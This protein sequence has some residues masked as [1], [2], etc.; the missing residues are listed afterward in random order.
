MTMRQN[1]RTY[2]DSSVYLAFLKGE[3][4]QAASGLTRAELARRILSSAE[5]GKLEIFTSAVTI[6]E[7]RRVG[8]S[9]IRFQPNALDAINA[10]FERTSTKMVE[11]SRELALRAQALATGYG[12]RTMDA[13]HLASAEFANC[14]ELFM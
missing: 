3:T 6:V 8:N 5:A 13:I 2:L 12:L 11:V 14:R 1:E 4:K 10:I 7:V 9:P